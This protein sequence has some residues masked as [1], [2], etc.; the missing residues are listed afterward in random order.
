MQHQK[1]YR[2]ANYLEILN[3]DIKLWVTLK[4]NRIIERGKKKNLLKCEIKSYLR[5]CCKRIYAK[6]IF[7]H[8]LCATYKHKT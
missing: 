4:S 2:K 3:I 6:S 7:K 8:E 1:I 5:M